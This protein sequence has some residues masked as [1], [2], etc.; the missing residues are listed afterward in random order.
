MLL[1]VTVAAMM[2]APGTLEG[3]EPVDSFFFS[4]N[5]RCLEERLSAEG[6]FLSSVVVDG[7]IVRA[8]GRCGVGIVVGFC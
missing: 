1:G 5:S 2:F 6:V 3:V 8:E 4:Y 7:A